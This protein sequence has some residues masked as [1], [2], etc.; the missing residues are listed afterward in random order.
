MPDETTAVGA[1]TADGR[2]EGVATDSGRVKVVEREAWA[3]EVKDDAAM[4]T[5]VGT[6]ILTGWCRPAR[7]ISG[8]KIRSWRRRQRAVRGHAYGVGIAV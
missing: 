3:G 5:K 6:G 2:R 1:T 8:E 7:G 4:V